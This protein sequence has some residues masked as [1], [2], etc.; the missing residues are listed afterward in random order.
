MAITTRGGKGVNLTANEVDTNFLELSGSIGNI[1]T[2]T[3]NAATASRALTAV[4]AS[5]A[6]TASLALTAV[7]ASYALT[8]SYA[9]NGGGG[10]GGVSYTSYVAKI[11]GNPSYEGPTPGNPVTASVLENT[12]GLTINWTQ[13]ENVFLGVTYYATTLTG[14]NKS[15]VWIT[16]AAEHVIY[17]E[18][19]TDDSEMSP[20][21]SYELIQ[22]SSNTDVQLWKYAAG[23]PLNLE[24]MVE[25]RIYP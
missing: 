16:M 12:T 23:A 24:M 4:S 3:S 19:G 22:N 7:S 17:T 18:K 10:G 25:I 5:N 20:N 2:G 1:L 13:S 8:A 14:I 15:R 6:T 21:Y 9:M 11:I